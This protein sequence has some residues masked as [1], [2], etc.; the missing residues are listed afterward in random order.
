MDSPY[1]LAMPGWLPGLFPAR[2]TLS[3]APRLV[4]SEILAGH[5]TQQRIQQLGPA[6]LY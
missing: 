1:R 2:N 4:L 6:R 5:E 3:G